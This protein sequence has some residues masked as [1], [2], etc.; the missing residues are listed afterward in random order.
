MTHIQQL[1]LSIVNSTARKL[2]EQ[3]TNECSDDEITQNMVRMHPD[4]RGAYREKEFINYDDALK[5]LG[6]GYNRNKLSALAKAH[7]IKNYTFNNVHIGFKV[8][9]ILTLKR[10]LAKDKIKN[11]KQV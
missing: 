3:I 10:K 11:R 4:T 1:A 6:I 9:D 7:G 8:A 2:R 5:E